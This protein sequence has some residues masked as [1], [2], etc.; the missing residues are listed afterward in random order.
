LVGDLILYTMRLE[1]AVIECKRLL[2]ADCD[3]ASR[4]LLAKTAQLAHER[5][6]SGEVREMEHTQNVETAIMLREA[7]RLH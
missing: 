4:M 1:K 5:D 3:N 2:D 7:N 6:L